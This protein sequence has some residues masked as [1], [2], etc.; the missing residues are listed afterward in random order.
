MGGEDP[1]AAAVCLISRQPQ[2]KPALGSVLPTD[3]L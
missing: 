2:T 3:P 1:R